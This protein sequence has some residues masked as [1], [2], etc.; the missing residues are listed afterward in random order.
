VHTRVK[1]KNKI[2]IFFEPKVIGKH[3]RKEI[4]RCEKDQ[5]QLLLKQQG[6]PKKDIMGARNIILIAK[7]FIF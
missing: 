7:N 2:K 1:N 4:E 3:G 5:N 6:M